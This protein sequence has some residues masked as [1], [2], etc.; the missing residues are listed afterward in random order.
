MEK[1]KKFLENNDNFLLTTHINADGDAYASTLAVAQILKKLN[2]SYR[3]I[4]PDSSKENRFSFLPFFEEVECYDNSNSY[5]RF[6]AAVICDAPGENRIPGVLSL[7]PPHEFRL[8]IDHH[9][10]ENSLAGVNLL[11]VTASSAS[12]LVY[13]VVK[14]FYG[15]MD[16]NL[17]TTIYAGISYDTGRFSFSNTSP[18]DYLI[19]AE[20]MEYN[21]NISE[22]NDKMFFSYNPIALKVIGYGLSSLE[23]LENGQIG[24]IYIPNYLLKEVNSGD[25]DELANYSVG[26]NGVKVGIYIREISDHS[27]KISLRTR[28]DI[29][30]NQVAAVFGGGGHVKAAGCRIEG[31]YET[32]LNK[33]V[34]EIKKY[35]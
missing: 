13:H 33:L 6:E 9:P 17:A 1:I 10:A 19:A 4:L 25:I 32:V 15:M 26:I 20:L 8:K 29:P 31:S 3:I 35:W 30:V 5:S 34:N 24:L 23:L 14:S 28:T 27:F 18:E 21:V 11:D 12:K 7:L 2:K 16:Q 22:I